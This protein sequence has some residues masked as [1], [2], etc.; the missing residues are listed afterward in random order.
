M[1]LVRPA[2]I[3]AAGLAGLLGLIWFLGGFRPAL[4]DGPAR[5]VG[6]PV[7]SRRWTIAVQR[8]AY[9]DTDLSGVDSDPAVRVWLSIVNTTDET[10]PLLDERIVSARIG[11]VELPPGR[12]GWGQ[13]RG[14]SSFD[15]DVRVDLAYDFPLPAGTPIQPEIAVVIRDEAM[16]KNFVIA[17]NWRVT[18]PA[19]TVRLPCP[20]ERTRG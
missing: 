16:A 4:P 2:A 13:L 17:D 19:A 5:A 8:A 7:E 3:A 11:G 18:Q 15:P 6:E 20:D 1:T 12:A 14:S 9:V 10:Q